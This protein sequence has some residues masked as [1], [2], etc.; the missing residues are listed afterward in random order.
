MLFSLMPIFSGLD[1]AMG[2][3]LLVSLISFELMPMS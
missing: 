2:F 3:Q 1:A